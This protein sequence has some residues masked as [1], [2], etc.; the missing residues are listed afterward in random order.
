[1]CL[2]GH[3]RQADIRRPRRP[4]STC[5]TLSPALY[6]RCAARTAASG[7]ASSLSL[8]CLPILIGHSRGT[9]GP[10]TS[11]LEDRCTLTRQREEVGPGSA[12]VAGPFLFV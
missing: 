7:L 9:W 3:E 11:S 6:A 10:S 1:M 8:T 12:W 2:A 5:L 4:G